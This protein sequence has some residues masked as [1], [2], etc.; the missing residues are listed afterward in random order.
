M[1]FLRGT[2]RTF[3]FVLGI[4]AST[5]FVT[6]VAYVAATHFMGYQAMPVL[7]GSMEPTMKTGGLAF[8]KPI[9][10]STVRKGDVVTFQQPDAPKGTYI[11]HRI[12]KVEMT[13]Q[14]KIYTTRG[15]ANRY[16]DPWNLKA[17]GTVG[18][19]HFDLPYAGYALVELGRRSV[20]Q[21]IF[22]GLCGA[23]LLLALI[24]IWKRP[25]AESS[26]TDAA[27]APRP[28]PLTD[29]SPAPSHPVDMRQG[30]TG[31]FTRREKTIKAEA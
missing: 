28:A 19:L 14:G 26:E 9:D 17:V 24:S 11:T 12:V 7:S 20:R 16:P 2:Y 15:D 21:T 22:F 23:F 18:K 30:R 8:V 3:S 1:S 10:A 13:D 4:V 25:S 29:S 27:A 31:R 6:A 5:I